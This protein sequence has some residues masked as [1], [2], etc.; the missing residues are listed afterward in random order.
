MDK[1]S[2]FGELLEA[3]LKETEIPEDLKKASK[4]ENYQE[5]RYF[6]RSSNEKLS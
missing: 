1:F 5:M 2:E 3:Y 6:I 4:D